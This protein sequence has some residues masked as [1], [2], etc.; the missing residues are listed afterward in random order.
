MPSFTR[1]ELG[2]G[3]QARSDHFHLDKETIFLNHGAFGATLK[4]AIAVM[5]KWQIHIEKQP[6]RFM[7]RELMPHLVYVIRRLAEFIN[8]NREDLVLL[9]NVT[10]GI[11]SV[12]RAE[13]LQAGDCVFIMSTEYGANKKILHHVYDHHHVNIVEGRMKFPVENKQQILCQIME[14]MPDNTKMAV[15]DHIPSN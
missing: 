5:Q 10:T 1:E 13:Q 6:V 12:I 9:P 2:Y 7:D 15:F 3:D 11:N 4:E 8:C 14:D